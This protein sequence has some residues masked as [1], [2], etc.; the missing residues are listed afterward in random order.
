MPGV[1]WSTLLRYVSGSFM[2][3][4]EPAMK[5]S[6]SWR[7]AGF[8]AVALGAALALPGVARAAD[9]TGI[10]TFTK[11]VPSPRQWPDD[12]V[13]QLAAKLGAPALVVKS[14]PWTVP[15]IGQDA[16]WRPAVET[17]L[18]EPRWVKA[19]EIRPSTV[20]MRK[21]THHALARLQ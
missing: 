21:V 17:G 10:P 13:W 6:R 8:G 15:A 9:T 20:A 1:P 11:D 16:W 3:K 14:P 5:P 7:Y 2:P 12:T 19:I 18:T 4:N